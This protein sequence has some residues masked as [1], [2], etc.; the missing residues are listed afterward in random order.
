MILDESKV[1]IPMMEEMIHQIEEQQGFTRRSISGTEKQSGGFDKLSETDSRI[2]RI[3]QR[4]V[5]TA[6]RIRRYRGNAGLVGEA[7]QTHSGTRDRESAMERLVGEVEQREQFI[8]DTERDIT[9]T[10][11]RIEQV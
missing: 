1:V 8:A 7:G 4:I 2:D 11:Q 9:E 5:A 3:K 10:N 6:G